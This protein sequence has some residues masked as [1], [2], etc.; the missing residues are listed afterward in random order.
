MLLGLLV[1]S[2]EWQR[3]ETLGFPERVACWYLMRFS[4]A[5]GPK[6]WVTQLQ[7]V[8]VRGVSMGFAQSFSSGGLFFEKVWARVGEFLR[9]RE[10]GDK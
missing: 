1:E 8:K 5:L 7:Y 4:V 2:G 9:I 3:K 10:S 6:W